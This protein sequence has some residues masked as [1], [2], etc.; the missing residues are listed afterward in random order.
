MDKKSVFIIEDEES[1]Y[2]EIK[3]KIVPAGL[4]SLLD[5]DDPSSDGLSDKETESLNKFKST[6]TGSLRRSMDYIAQIIKE[7]YKEIRLII[8]DLRINSDDNAGS[9]IIEMI[10]KN[11]IPDFNRDWYCEDIPIVI[12]SKLIDQEKLKAYE[13]SSGNCFFLSKD[14]AFTSE[15]SGLLRSI[16]Y[17]L[18]EQFNDKYAKNDSEKK[19]KVALSFTNDNV[20]EDGKI[21][22]IRNF[23]HEVAKGLYAKYSQEKVFFDMDQQEESN[24]KDVNYFT[25]NYNNAEYVLVFVSEGYKNKKSRWSTAEWEVIKNLDLKNKVIFVAIDSTLKESDFNTHLGI[26]EVIYKDMLPWCSD[27]NNLLSAK[28]NDCVNYIKDGFWEKSTVQMMAH[29]IE[30]YRQESSK[31]IKEAVDFIIKTIET[32]ENQAM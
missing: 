2:K 31:I 21:L 17:R 12:I 4:I 10:R 13:K 1:D 6:E 28:N 5:K 30:M 23:I 14:T 11:H 8:C 25:D 22:K 9:Q 3:F 19:Y 16:V 15:G 20:V 27:Y 24:G 32:R 26:N 18:S 29:A 7:N